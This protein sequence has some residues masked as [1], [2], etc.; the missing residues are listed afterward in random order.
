[1]TSLPVLRKSAAELLASV[2]IDLFPGALLF[3]CRSTEVGFYCDIVANQPIDHYALPLLEEKMRGLTKQNLEIRALDMMREVASNYLEHKGQSLRARSAAHAKDNILSLIQIG[4]FCDYCQLPYI[5]HTGEA[6]F[7][8]LVG[9]EEVVQYIPD[10]DSVKVKRISGIVSFD[11]SSLKKEM[12][13]LQAGK[14]ADHTALPVERKLFSLHPEVSDWTWFWETEGA[15]VKKT[16]TGWWEE[17]HRKQQF[18]IVS[19]PPLVK[20]EL[21]LKTGI[22]EE[23]GFDEDF[24]PSSLEIQGVAYRIPSTP[25]ASHLVLFKT[26]KPIE[27]KMPARYAECA[28]FVFQ[29]QEGDLWGMLNSHFVTADFAYIFCS[30]QQ[31][32]AEF[33]SSLQFI[34]KIIKMFDFEYYWRFI[35]RGEKFAGSVI[36]WE[37]AVES[38]N[39]AFK[40]CGFAYESDVQESSFAG[41]VVEAR[42][43]D[44]FGREWKGPSLTLNFSLPTK[45]DL[46]YQAADGKEYAPLMLVRRLFGSVERFVA[47]LLEHN[48]GSLPLWLVP[49]QVH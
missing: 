42:I 25:V 43:L 12:K 34:D 7:F 28:P 32:E 41:P 21:F 47:L 46:R 9:I 26:Q 35:G 30:P 19:T 23:D 36:R 8:K 13:A 16:L 3:Q 45:F 2:A 18:N 24:D 10:E 31:L 44:R 33:I 4:D 40:T 11:K 5:E 15:R 39:S 22:L 6:Q 38:L 29:K 20:E 49:E 14:K 48:S 37:K 27:R 17:E 1:M